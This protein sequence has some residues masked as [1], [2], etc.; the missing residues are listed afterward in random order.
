MP[1]LREWMILPP[2][3]W[4]EAQ[5]KQWLDHCLQATLLGMRPVVELAS[6]HGATVILL[7]AV[8]RIA[9]ANPDWSAHALDELVKLSEAL[10]K[11]LPREETRH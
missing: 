9:E 2:A 1:I 7:M 11:L 4:S 8:Y 5:T 6:P 3:Y 10:E